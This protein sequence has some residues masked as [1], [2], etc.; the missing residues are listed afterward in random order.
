[1]DRSASNFTLSRLDDFVPSWMDLKEVCHIIEFVVNEDLSSFGHF[2]KL[3]QIIAIEIQFG[4]LT[5]I[6]VISFK[7]IPQNAF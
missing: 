3:F 4:S 2:K 7:Q 1:M 6:E 5:R